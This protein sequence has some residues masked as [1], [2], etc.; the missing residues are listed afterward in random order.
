M[1]FAMQ[2]D[3]RQKAGFTGVPDVDTLWGEREVFHVHSLSHA[4]RQNQGSKR[5]TAR[6]ISDDGDRGGGVPARAS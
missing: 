2:S 1:V 5:A 6:R 4:S 3:L